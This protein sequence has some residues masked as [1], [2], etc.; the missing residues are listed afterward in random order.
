ME[1]PAATPS[2][3]VAAQLAALDLDPARPLLA[4]DCDEVMVHFAAHLAAYLDGRGY[5]M[6]L[7][8]YRLEG[9]IRRRGAPDPV[10]FDGAIRLIG[11]FFDEEVTRQDAIEGA[12][13]ALARLARLAQIVVLTNVPGAARRGRVENLAALSMGY[14]L[15][16]NDG[17]KGAAFAWMAARTG[18][19]A[20]FIDDSPN[21]IAS[22]KSAWPAAEVLHFRGSPFIAG[23]LPDCPQA[24]GVVDDWT[25]AEARLTELFTRGDRS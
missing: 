4:V 9:A 8:Q 16:Q 25:A 1:S 18:T 21:Q 20:V 24:D 17:G 11:D 5:E 2:E 14:P 23:V 15:I 3:G 7:T 13:A 12:V 22:V 6:T 19:P 10:P